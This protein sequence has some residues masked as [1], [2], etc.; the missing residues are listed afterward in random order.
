[1][2]LQIAGCSVAPDIKIYRNLNW[3]TQAALSSINQNIPNTQPTPANRFGLLTG[4]GGIIPDGAQ[5]IWIGP[6]SEAD[7]VW[8]HDGWHQGQ[9]FLVS[10]GHPFVGL[11]SKDVTLYQH[12]P[13]IISSASGAH[14][15]ELHYIP[16]GQPPPFASL[17][18]MR[19]PLRRYQALTVP[20]AADTIT[21][22]LVPV[23]GRRRVMLHVDASAAD[24]NV[25]VT[26]LAAV[27]Y[28]DMVVSSGVAVPAFAAQTAAAT[29][30]VA[31]TQQLL[32][33]IGPGGPQT[34]LGN[35]PWFDADF[36]AVKMSTTVDTD[37]VRIGWVALDF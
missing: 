3:G 31:G 18:T 9:P 10:V 36:V 29:V 35:A 30:V 13:S 33:V 4:P 24:H 7:A 17:P 28:D 21:S 11:L 5:A 20:V 19:A 27:A 6:N 23:M 37:V 8:V 32:N 16:L 26:L 22:D 25:S 15:L 14:V 34:T 12:T 2:A 1:M